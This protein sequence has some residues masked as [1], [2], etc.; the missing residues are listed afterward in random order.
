MVSRYL[1]VI[2]LIIL[3][4]GC[5]SLKTIVETTPTTKKIY[6]KGFNKGYNEA[7]YK[8]IDKFKRLCKH[9][10]IITLDGNNYICKR[11]LLSEK[12]KL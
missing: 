4:I 8:A 2:T 10:L 9:N 5:Q 12:E 6:D 1:T 11:D 3:T 7:I